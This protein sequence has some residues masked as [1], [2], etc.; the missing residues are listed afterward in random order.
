MIVVLDNAPLNLFTNPNK[1]PETLACREWIKKL[2]KSRISICL[3]EIIYYE[4]RRQRLLNKINGEPGG[5]ELLEEFK[6][7]ETIYYQPITTEIIIKATELWALARKKNES[8]AHKESIDCDV[9]LAATAIVLA[10]QEQDYV[11]VATD[12]IDDIARYTDAK[13]WEDIMIPNKK[14]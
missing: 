8:T 7:S 3:P 1:K 13:K 6:D 11:I 2:I 5:L 10:Q 4:A 9:I 14:R 12:N